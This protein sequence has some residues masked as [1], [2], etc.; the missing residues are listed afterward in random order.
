MFACPLSPAPGTRQWPGPRPR[1]SPPLAP[2]PC[3]VCSRLSCSRITGSSQ[4]EIEAAVWSAEQGG[5]R[6]GRAGQG[7]AESRASVSQSAPASRHN[8]EG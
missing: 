2:V 3:S 1:M 5:G 4:R 8:S 6:E 7:R